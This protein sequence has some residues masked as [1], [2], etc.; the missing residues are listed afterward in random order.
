MTEQTQD[1]QANFD[2][3]VEKVSTKFSFRKV[4]VEVDGKP[5]GDFTKRPTVEIELPVITVEGVVAALQA[6]G[7]QLEL[8]IEACRQVQ[9]DRARELVNDK[10]DISA[11]NFQYAELAWEKIANL[12]KAERRG[13][14]IPKEVW[15]DFIKD[16]I[17][18]MPAATGKT[19][20]QVTNASKLLATKFQSI[21]TNKP[22]LKLLKDQ[23]AIYVN[24]SQQAES[25]SECVNFLAE[26]ADTLLN[27]DE[28][29]L[30]EAL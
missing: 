9:F 4:A 26:K 5:T 27:Q 17:T 28:A 8:V 10:E 21:K 11:D 13:G 19:V 30:L 2:N 15:E 1:I 24:A 23:L 22:V 12:P 14:G 6:G 18:V 20:D 25:F 3:K 29:A 7:K 16:Y